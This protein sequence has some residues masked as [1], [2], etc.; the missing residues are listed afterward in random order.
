M[1]KYLFLLLVPV[2]FIFAPT[3]TDALSVGVYDDTGQEIARTEDIGANYNRLLF[4]NAN[5]NIITVN[6]YFYNEYTFYT[7]Y[8]Y[9]IN[10]SYQLLKRNNTVNDLRNPS[11]GFGGKYWPT[12]NINSYSYG[13]FVQTDFCGPSTTY[14][15]SVSYNA[16][17]VATGQG[18]RGILSWNFLNKGAYVG[19]IV[20]RVEITNLSDGT[21][22][23]INNSTSQ[24]IQ[25]QNTNQQQTNE[26]LDKIES[27]ITS[28]D[29]P[30]LDG[31][32]N[33]V[34]WLPAGPV[35]SILNLPLS[36]FNNLTSVL[37]GSC[38]SA[39]LTLPFVNKNI[40]LPCISTL[41]EQIGIQSFLNWI[42]AIVSALILYNY[43][44][45]LY[46]WVD[47]TLTM[48]ENTWNDWGGV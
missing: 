29:S 31:L 17:F 41:Y 7:N 42:G 47:D 27:S 15:E 39:N 1:K 45:K 8:E 21:G 30:D 43:F 16:S 25:N 9:E 18:A 38:Q 19:I 23:I 2:I 46:K 48:R 3:K 24:I 5:P 4:C 14:S 44:L 13:Q 11:F 36:L 10:I 20:N 22:A 40:V 34:G 28:E 33:S 37:S 32:N 26:K 12:L 35:D 6:F